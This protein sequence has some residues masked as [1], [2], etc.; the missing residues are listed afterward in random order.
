MVAV[1]ENTMGFGVV[2]KLDCLVGTSCTILATVI[3]ATTAISHTAANMR[4]AIAN[5]GFM[6]NPDP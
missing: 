3:V 2:C 5:T 4:K 1:V 6:A